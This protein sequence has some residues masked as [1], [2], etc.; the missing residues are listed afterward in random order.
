[1]GLTE[2]NATSVE[3][4]S[5]PADKLVLVDAYWLKKYEGREMKIRI[6]PYQKPV[7]L[8]IE[9]VFEYDDDKHDKFSAPAFD[10]KFQIDGTIF[11]EKSTITIDYKQLNLW[12][13][14]RTYKGPKSN[15]Q[16]KKIYYYCHKN[17]I[18]DLCSLE[19]RVDLVDEIILK[20]AYWE[21]D[22]I[23]IRMLPH[24]KKVIL[25]V[26]LGF[27]YNKV[28]YDKEKAIFYL[29]FKV[30][31][32]I[33]QSKVLVIKGSDLLKCETVQDKKGNDCYIYKI[34]NF[35]SDLSEVEFTNR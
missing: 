16:N 29:K 1:M 7:D 9:F 34:E 6:L 15:C 20:D 10:L 23:K 13:P 3:N 8:Y 32:T 11:D 22:G 4:N 19:H 24:Q 35:T 28:N 27:K 33:F 17:F 30:P 31:N 26:V 21:K 14:I 25:K 18:S 5:K 2:E 12:N